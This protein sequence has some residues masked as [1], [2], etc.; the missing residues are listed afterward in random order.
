MLIK[1]RKDISLRR[2]VDSWAV[3]IVLVPMRTFSAN[4]MH[5]VANI[6]NHTALYDKNHHMRPYL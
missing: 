5:S 1:A 3:P 2:T 4:V 6:Y